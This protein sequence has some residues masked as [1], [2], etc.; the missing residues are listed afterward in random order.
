MRLMGYRLLSRSLLLS[1][2]EG[3]EG[4]GV[5]VCEEEA[6]SG[7]VNRF[8]KKTSGHKR[9]KVRKSKKGP[10]GTC[11]TKRLNKRLSCLTIRP[12]VFESQTFCFLFAIADTFGFAVQIPSEYCARDCI[13][14]QQAAR[15]DSNQCETE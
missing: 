2:D 3:R 15:H 12:D 4:A 10:S 14:I 1:R 8:K 13:M 9:S 6:D 7:V 11:R 5:V